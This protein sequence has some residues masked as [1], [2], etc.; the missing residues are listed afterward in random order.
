MFARY[1]NRVD[2]YA[3]YIAE[4]HPLDGWRMEENDRAGIAF[5][6]PKSTL[7]RTQ[8]AGMCQ[9]ALKISMPLL[10][11]KID[12]RVADAYAAAPDRLY[13][14]DRDGRVAYKSGRGPFGFKTGE[15]EQA[16]VLL[17]LSEGP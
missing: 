15:L 17:L 8:V 3:V 7:E 10:V 5:A 4:A 16:L 12:N 11:D 1:S 13:L 14:I 9:R 2:F 6:Q